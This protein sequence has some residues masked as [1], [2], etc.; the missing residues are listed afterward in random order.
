MDTIIEFEYKDE[1][2]MKID[3]LEQY[4]NALIDH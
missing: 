2:I 4:F 3:E 1:N